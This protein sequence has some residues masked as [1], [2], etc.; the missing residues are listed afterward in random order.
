MV[1]IILFG[2][3]S[4]GADNPEPLLSGQFTETAPVRGRSH[5]EFVSGNKL[6]KKETGSSGEDVFRYRMLSVNQ[7]EL[8]LIGDDEPQAQILEMERISQSKFII[9]NLYPD[10]GGEPTYMTFEKN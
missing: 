10:I 4:C 3:C 8:T 1:F 6:I 5:L 9:Q 7:I 2:L